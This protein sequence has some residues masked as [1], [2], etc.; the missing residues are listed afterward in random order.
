M[1]ILGLI[2]LILGSIGRSVGATVFTGDHSR[3]AP[4]FGGVP[5]PVPPDGGGA[6]DRA[7]AGSGPVSARS[8]P[9]AR[10]TPDR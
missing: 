10:R 5:S 2:L 4:V 1:I 3:A 9:Y 7:P 6:T 8:A